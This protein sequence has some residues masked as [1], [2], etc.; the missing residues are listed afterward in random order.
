MLKE[1]YNKCHNMPTI[2]FTPR[3][4]K[5]EVL[6]HLYDLSYRLIVHS[7]NFIWSIMPLKNASCACLRLQL[8]QHTH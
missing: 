2:V 1:I 3:H 7:T 8:Q 4:Y 5:Q 6:N